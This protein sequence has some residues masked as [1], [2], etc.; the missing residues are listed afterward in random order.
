MADL[1]TLKSGPACDPGQSNIYSYQ[2]AQNKNSLNKEKL[3]TISLM[4]LWKYLNKILTH[5]KGIYLKFNEEYQL[6]YNRTGTEN[7]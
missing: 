7:Q 1:P 4:N 6:E 5:W 3:H 2:M